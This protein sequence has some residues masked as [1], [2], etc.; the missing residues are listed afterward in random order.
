MKPP[1]A[2]E[3]LILCD[4]RKRA[5][6][7]IALPLVPLA[8]WT[9]AQCHPTHGPDLATN[10]TE[11]QLASKR[12]GPLAPLSEVGQSSARAGHARLPAPA[13]LRKDWW[14]QPGRQM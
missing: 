4:V 13:A 5:W 11:L 6:P 9:S 12:L 14:S 10:A 2:G 1:T 8:W 7:A 3:N